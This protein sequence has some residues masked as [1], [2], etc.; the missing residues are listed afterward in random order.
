ME[1]RT[2]ALLQAKVKCVPICH[3]IKQRFK[4][5]FEN[6]DFWC[7]ENSGCYSVVADCLVSLGF[8][9]A[10][11]KRVA[12]LQVDLQSSE[13][14]RE[15]LVATVKARGREVHELTGDI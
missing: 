6:C 10:F 3:I 2:L 12:E 15:Q 5:N 8:V 9:A 14:R 13:T 11:D 1:L 4:K 7:F